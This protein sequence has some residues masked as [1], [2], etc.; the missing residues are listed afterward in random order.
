MAEG[1]M[2]F[3]GVGGEIDGKTN[4]ELHVQPGDT[5]HLVLINDDGM[6]HDLALP[7]LDA[8]IPPIMGIGESSEIVF[9]VGVDQQ[10]TYP[11]FC[12]IPGHRQA[13]ME[14]VLVV[15]GD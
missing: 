5:V 10:G 7:D 6:Q 3:I 4:P 13:G 1:R 9:T 12:T 2:V 8:H 11:Y 15:A 14:G